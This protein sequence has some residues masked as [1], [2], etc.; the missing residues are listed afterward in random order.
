M[1]A[2][3]Q[4]PLAALMHATQPTSG[5]GKALIAKTHSTNILR[6]FDFFS[7]ICM[8][9]AFLSVSL[10]LFDFL[11]DGFRLNKQGI[12]GYTVLTLTFLPPLAMVIVKPGIYL[13]ALNNAGIFC[14]VL[15]L[16]I[17][18]IMSWRYRNQDKIS[19][20]VKGQNPILLLL[21][22]SGLFCMFIPYVIKS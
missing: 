15:L 11:A 13:S 16:I 3:G 20:I 18:A 10:G 22:L 19:M 12:Q 8:L 4:S 5:V 1:G 17:P 21:I 14:T 6:L 9:T 7:C 2:V